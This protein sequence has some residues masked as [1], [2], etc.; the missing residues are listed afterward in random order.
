MG[1]PVIIR[2]FIVS[3]NQKRE[4]PKILNLQFSA[5]AVI[6][7]STCEIK[8]N[9]EGQRQKSFEAVLRVLTA[10]GLNIKNQKW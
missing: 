6:R 1:N 9:G 3:R 8:K 10:S 5:P 7:S 4:V 2:V